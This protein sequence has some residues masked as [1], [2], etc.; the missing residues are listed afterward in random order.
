MAIRHYPIM[1]YTVTDLNCGI[2]LN[3][4][5]V[6]TCNKKRFDVVLLRC[7]PPGFDKE[8]SIKCQ[9]LQK[10]NCAIKF[11]TNSKIDVIC[12]EISNLVVSTCQLIFWELA[13]IIKDGP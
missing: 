8:H 9:L 10:L 5:L 1:P 3:C 12:K 11:Y 6:L 13:Y 2:G 7:P 4:N